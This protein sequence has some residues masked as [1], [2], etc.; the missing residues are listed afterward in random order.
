MN[1]IRTQ[2]LLNLCIQAQQKSGAI[3]NF[4]LYSDGGAAVFVDK[5]DKDIYYGFYTEKS[6]MPT[7]EENYHACRK[8]LL[9]LIKEGKK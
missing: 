2:E 5:K 9:R 7:T 8:H 6:S 4:S 1:Q 3:I